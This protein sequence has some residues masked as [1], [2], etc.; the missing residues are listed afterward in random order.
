[1]RDY[2]NFESDLHEIV[3][4]LDS[5]MSDETGET[6]MEVGEFDGEAMID[7]LFAQEVGRPAARAARP[8]PNLRAAIERQRQR[9]AG[10]TRAVR[11]LAA[12]VRRRGGRLVLA[13]PRSNASQI[14]ARLGI[15][16]RGV[17]ILARSAALRPAR[18]VAP[19]ARELDMEAGGGSC[20]GRSDSARYWWGYRLWLNECQTKALIGAMKAGAG[21]ANACAAIGGPKE[22]CGTF[23]GVLNLGAGVVEGVDSLGGNRGV[24][25]SQP[26]LGVAPPVV[27][28]Q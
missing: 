19:M 25:I 9:N 5:E 11:G 10:F 7:E 12:H 13:I 20:P 3:A 27:W 18:P 21:A 2:E 6:A 14:A 24:V 16:P 8:P 23:A 15:K 4:G 26:W 22:Y 1:M 28:H 17:E